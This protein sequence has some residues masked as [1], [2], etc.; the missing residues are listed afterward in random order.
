MPENL[1][2]VELTLRFSR[3]AQDPSSPFHLDVFDVQMALGSSAI[4]EEYLL[5]A[6]PATLQVTAN[7]YAILTNRGSIRRVV[8]DFYTGY[9]NLV[10]QD[11]ANGQ[12]PTKGPT[13]FRV[14]GLDQTSDIVMSEAKQSQLGSCDL[15]RPTRMELCSLDR[16][17]TIPGT[18][19]ANRFCT[20]LEAWMQSN[21]TGPYGAVR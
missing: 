5:D 12:Y 18:P 21:Y 7:R 1:P 17:L 14:T 11:A 13:E 20:Q 10:N 19:Y 2:G 3:H 15:D 4:V 8:S 16:C 6:K 9:P